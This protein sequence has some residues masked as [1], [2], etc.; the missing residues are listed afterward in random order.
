MSWARYVV[1]VWKKRKVCRVLVGKPEVE[2]PLG[3]PHRIWEDNF[4]IDFKEIVWWV[5]IELICLMT[6]TSGGLYTKSCTYVYYKMQGISWLGEEV[7]ALQVGLCSIKLVG[8]LVSQCMEFIKR[9]P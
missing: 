7:A 5:L 9:K 6:W 8:W 3:T 4:K 1:Q 2:R